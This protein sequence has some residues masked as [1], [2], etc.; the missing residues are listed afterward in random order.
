MPKTQL[1]LL[2]SKTDAENELL[3]V[4]YILF[5]YHKYLKLW[6]QHYGAELKAR[7][8]F[9]QD[10]ADKWITTNVAEISYDNNGNISLI[11]QQ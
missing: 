2:I 11:K 7:L 10:K 5:Q 1:K 6:Q 9:W 8:D 3:T 4:G